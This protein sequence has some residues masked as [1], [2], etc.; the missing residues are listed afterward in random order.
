[1]PM[2]ILMLMLISTDADG[3][4]SLISMGATNA[5]MVFEK[6]TI[7][8]KH[9]KT[10]YIQIFSVNWWQR[11]QFLQQYVVCLVFTQTK[12]KL[13]DL[14]SEPGAVGPNLK[15][16]VH[17][18]VQDLSK[19]GIGVGL[20]CNMYACLFTRVIVYVCLFKFTR[21]REPESDKKSPIV[22]SPVS[23]STWLPSTRS[24]FM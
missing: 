18:E 7:L 15:G 22:S 21:V 12:R 6:I 19:V 9:F 16:V 8:S 13:P 4:N 3:L 20:L 14:P 24:P 11:I 23:C 2:P 10:Y 1:M 17:I 5:E